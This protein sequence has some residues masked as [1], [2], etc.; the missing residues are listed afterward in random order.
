MNQWH[1]SQIWGFSHPDT[2]HSMTHSYLWHDSLMCATWLIHM[3]DLMHSY[4]WH[5]PWSYMGHGVWKIDVT[6]HVCPMTQWNDRHFN[7]DINSPYAFHWNAY[8]ELMSLCMM[9]QF[10]CVPWL[11]VPYK[12]MVRIWRIDVSLFMCVPW[13]SEMIVTYSRHINTEWRR[14]IGCLIFTG[15][16]PQKSPI[17]S[18]SFAENNLQLR[19]SC[20]SSPSCKWCHDQ[21]QWNDVIK[22]CGTNELWSLRN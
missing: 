16:F 2:T 5:G 14:V 7:S 11:Y 12:T 17:I 9:S 18:G 1:D 3:C 20:G 6:I 4:L 21:Y 15:H 10:M 19:A 8:R 22:S 13:L